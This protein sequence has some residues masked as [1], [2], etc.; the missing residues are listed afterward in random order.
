[1]NDIRYD[2]LADY[3]EFDEYS[4]VADSMLGDENPPNKIAP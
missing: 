1:M 4:V 3:S 2:N